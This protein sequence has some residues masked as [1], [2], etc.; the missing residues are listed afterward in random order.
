MQKANTECVCTSYVQALTR[1][2]MYTD[3]G[4]TRSRHQVRVRAK[5]VSYTPK[6]TSL[7]ARRLLP[8]HTANDVWGPCAPCGQ[9]EGQ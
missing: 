5:V 3:M 9:H 2:V 4:L 1:N 6:R 7:H 8:V